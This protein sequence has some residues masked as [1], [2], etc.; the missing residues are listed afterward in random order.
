MGITNRFA[1]KNSLSFNSIASTL[2]QNEEK[3][4]TIVGLRLEDALMI[5]SDGV[6]KQSLREPFSL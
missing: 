1:V 4:L 5:Y 2:K 3:A 6:R